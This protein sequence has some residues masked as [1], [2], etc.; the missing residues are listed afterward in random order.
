MVRKA[1]NGHRNLPGGEVTVS[2]EQRGCVSPD[3]LLLPSD[4]AGC[5][6]ELRA[7]F[8]YTHWESRS[9][10]IIMAVYPGAHANKYHT[11]P[12]TSQDFLN[13]TL[14]P[15]RILP[16]CLTPDS[17]QPSPPFQ[18]AVG[19]SAT[20]AL[21][22][23]TTSLMQ[24]GQFSKLQKPFDSWVACWALSLYSSSPF[25]PSTLLPRASQSHQFSGKEEK[26]R[27][28]GSL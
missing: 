22:L 18:K 26:G 5:M 23:P 27:A 15:G 28:Q 12:Q 24:Q 16:I 9:N 1:E 11:A 4:M 21:Q 19:F 20:Y 8:V 2:T 17:C 14:A 3:N 13:S 25:P 7:R 6:T 10:L